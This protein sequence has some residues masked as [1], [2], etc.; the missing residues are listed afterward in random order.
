V[1]KISIVVPVHNEEG[2]V[3][4]LAHALQ[5]VMASLNYT[6]EILFVDDGS[7]DRSLNI[8]RRLSKAYH[9][10]FF[11]KL[12]R[13][14]GHQNAIK[15]GIDKAVGDCVITMDG[16][17][18]HPPSLLPLMI[19]KWEEGY[20]IVYTRRQ[21]TADCG[22]FKRKTSKW[23]YTLM[24]LL[25]DVKLEEGTAD[26]RLLDTKVADIIRNTKAAELFLRALVKLTGFEQFAL[27]YK[28]EARFS[29]KS[30]FG[31]RK[32]FRFAVQGITAYSSKPLHLATYLGLIFSF[33]ALIYI[34]YILISY[35]FGHA[36]NGWSSII[37]TIVFFGGLQLF[38][39][40]IIGIY[41]GKIFIQVK[42]GHHYIIQE[43][44][45][46]ETH[47]VAKL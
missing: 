6:F 30:K 18:Q 47:A 20:D 32:M 34:P 23:F 35:F 9:N 46:Y 1:K 25:A 12:A 17:M 31:I 11:I 5:S 13:N 10:I 16:D 33:G 39:L 24:N 37:A 3:E 36:V 44:N 28:A 29:G 43:T 4:L 8:I 2:N 14:Y 42:Q 27:D 45:I 40:G 41:I 22:W 15:A 26:F 19:E 7:T 21:E 38:V